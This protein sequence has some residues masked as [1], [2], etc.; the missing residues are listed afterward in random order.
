MIERYD[1]HSFPLSISLSFRN[2]GFPVLTPILSERDTDK[3]RKKEGMGM[4]MLTD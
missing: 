2:A 4:E 3:R 1:D